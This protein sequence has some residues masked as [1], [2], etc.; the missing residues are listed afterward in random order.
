GRR[1]TM[2]N[3]LTWAQLDSQCRKQSGNITDSDIMPA[4]RQGYLNSKMMKIYALLDGVNDPWYNRSTTLTAAAD[5]E[6]LYDAAN[7]AGNITALDATAKTITRNIGVFVAGSIIS[8]AE[9]W[10]ATSQITNSFIGLITIGGATATFTILKGGI[11][12]LSAS[13][14]L[15]VLVLKSSSQVACDI[16]TLYVKD[17]LSIYDNAY[18]STPGQI[19]VFDLLKDANRFY[20]RSL[21]VDAIKRIAAYQARDTVYLFIGS[22]AN[23]LGTISAEYRG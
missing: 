15:S 7:N 10:V 12:T 3:F 17:F 13:Y 16:S 8:V 5:Q 11:T 1:F 18:A 2:L 21:D 9:V 14:G 19:R 22:A 4:T 23:A 6:Q 20:Q